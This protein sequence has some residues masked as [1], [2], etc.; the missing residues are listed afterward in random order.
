M[1]KIV[2]IFQRNHG[3]ARMKELKAAGVQSRDINRLIQDAVIEKVKP[4][5]YRLSR[6]PEIGGVPIGFIDVCQAMPGGV[7]CLLSALAYYD[8]ITFNP[9][10]IFVAIPHAHKLVKIEYPPIRKFFFRDRFYQCGIDTIDTHYGKIKIYD[11]EKS[12]CDLFRY[13][14]KLGEDLALEAL[15][16]HLRKGNTNINKLMDYAVRCQV[17]TILTPYI[18]I[19][20][21]Q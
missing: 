16:N 20:I 10:Q 19:L 17:K 14:K 15:K 12:I 7:I 11:P 1:Q 9:S 2:S 3:Y 13:R 5:L 6:L 18:K 8:L 21:H 4:G